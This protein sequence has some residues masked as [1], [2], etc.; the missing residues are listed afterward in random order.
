MS[1]IIRLG[2]AVAVAVIIVIIAPYLRIEQVQFADIPVYPGATELAEGA[3]PFAEIIAERMRES[4]SAHAGHTMVTY[5]IPAGTS[6]EDLRSFYREAIEASGKG[7]RYKQEL[8]RR[9]VEVSTIGWHRGGVNE[10]QLLVLA[11]GGDETPGG[12]FLIVGLY[13]E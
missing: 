3:H 5:A 10:E 1:L 6:W 11:Y 2:I 4:V 8:E 12:A 7:W 9:G 13:H